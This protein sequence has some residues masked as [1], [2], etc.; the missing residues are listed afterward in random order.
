MKYSIEDGWYYEYGKLSDGKTAM[1]TFGRNWRNEIG[2]GNDYCVA[3]AIAN[4]KKIIKQYLHGD[5][6]GDLDMTITG[7]GSTE[8]LLWAFNKVKEFIDTELK[9]KDRVIVYGSDSRRM[10][11][12]E[13]FL[14]RRLRFRKIKDPYW[15]WC[16]AYEKSYQQEEQ[17]WRKENQQDII[18][19]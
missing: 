13:H 8:G 2:M 14:T 10:R 9:D 17:W 18:K 16:L 19:E 11:I 15:G 3:F 5:G 4:K 12:Y 1:I 6:H 7:S